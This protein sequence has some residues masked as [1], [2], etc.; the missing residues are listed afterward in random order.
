MLNEERWKEKKQ[1][2]GEDVPEQ[3]QEDVEKRKN[4]WLVTRNLV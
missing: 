3:K 4:I 2:I 1:K